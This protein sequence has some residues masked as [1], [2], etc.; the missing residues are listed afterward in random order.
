MTTFNIYTTNNTFTVN[1]LTS[2]Q[3][4]DLLQSNLASIP[5]IVAWD[6]ERCNFSIT[7]EPMYKKT[8]ERWLDYSFEDWTATDKYYEV[9][10]Y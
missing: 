7:L 9:I 2:E 1:G 4:T 6:D 3:V 8:F 10:E 5:V